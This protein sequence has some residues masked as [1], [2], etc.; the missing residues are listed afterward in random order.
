MGEEA[1]SNLRHPLRYFLL[2]QREHTGYFKLEWIEGEIGLLDLRRFYP[3]SVSKEMVDAAMLFLSTANAIIIDVR[4]N[5]G[6]AGESLQYFCSYFLEYPTQ[7]TSDYSRETDFRTEFWTTAE[8]AGTRRTDVPVFILTGQN[9]FSSAEAFAY[10]MQVNGRAT[11]VGDSTG[12]GAHSVDL[13]RIDDLFEIYIP[14]ARAINPITSDNWEGIGVIPDV[15]VPSDAALDTALVLARAAAAEYGAAHDESLSASVDLMQHLLG[16]AEEL[17][18]A[19]RSDEARLVL[20]SM[21]RLGDEHGLN[22]EFFI[23]VLAYN[24]DPD[25]EILYAIVNKWIEL[26]P[27]SPEPW[28]W[29]A[30]AYAASGRNELAIECYE[31]VLELNPADPNAGRRVERLRLRQ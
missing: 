7:L 23:F 18:R 21:F 5:G 31:K 1:E 26:F 15:L 20:D 2:G 30:S 9:S 24:Y 22:N 19:G 11:L 10:D 6:G 12:G 28:Q 14:T 17:Y 27:E 13:Y 4:E 29:L 25:E 8:V 16:D 3:L